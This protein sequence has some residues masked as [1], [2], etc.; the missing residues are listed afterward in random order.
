MDQDDKNEQR[1][2]VS[3]K[4]P[5]DKQE[6]LEKKWDEK[7][8]RRLVWRTR[9]LVGKSVVGSLFFLFVLYVLYMVPVNIV[10]TSSGKDQAFVRY[11]ATLVETTHT[12]LMM[13][14]WAVHG[15]AEINAFLTQSATLPVYRQVGDWRVIVGEVKAKKWLF[16]DV[17]YSLELKRKYVDEQEE[18]SFAVPPELIGQTAD[19][20][21]ASDHIWQQI[22]QIDNGYVAQMAFSTMTAMTPEELRK[23]LARYNLD[24]LQ[25]PVYAGELTAVKQ[26]S[27]SGS[28]GYRYVPHFTLRPAVE[29]HGSG[30]SRDGQLNGSDQVQRAQK[31]MLLDI[32]WLQQNGSYNGKEN[33]ALRSAYLKKNPLKVYGA[34]VTGPIRELEKLQQEAD[35]HD[36]QLGDIEVW[37]WSRERSLPDD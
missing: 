23:R 20:K 22:K 6:Q 27:Y 24:I 8:A 32:D 14:N 5:E 34:V 1:M 29:Y 2:L 36:F 37:K 16:G 30:G 7:R 31:Q 19:K 12:G 25:M 4:E 33:D 21:Q 11:V 18:F 17:Q 13:E 9:L 10:Y 3:W 15:D 28:N 26:I 35:F